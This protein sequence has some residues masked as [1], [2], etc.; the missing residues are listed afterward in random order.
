MVCTKCGKE[1]GEG[2]D[3]GHKTESYCAKTESENSQDGTRRV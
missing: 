1:A 3:R 2:E